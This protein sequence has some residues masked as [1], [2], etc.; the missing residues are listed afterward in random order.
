VRR[1]PSPWRF[2]ANAE[3]MLPSPMNPT[4]IASTL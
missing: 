4:R 1:W 2:A 3:P